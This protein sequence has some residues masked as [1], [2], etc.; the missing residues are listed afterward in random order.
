MGRVGR[1]NTLTLGFSRSQHALYEVTGGGPY[2]RHS[3]YSKHS[4]KLE[5]EES[6]LLLLQLS[7]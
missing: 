2:S 3:N 6:R 7:R 4:G 1:Q 5:G